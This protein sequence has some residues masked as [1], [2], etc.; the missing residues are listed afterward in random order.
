MTAVRYPNL[1]ALCNLLVPGAGLLIADAMVTGVVVGLIFVVSANIALWG[2]LLIPDELAPWLTGLSIGV[3]GG[4]YV[5]AQLRLAQTVRDRQRRS[6]VARRREILHEVKTLLQREEYRAAEAALAPLTDLAE[7]DLLVAYRFAQAQL[8]AENMGEARRA[9]ERVR[10]L[11]EDRLYHAQ[12]ATAERR[13]EQLGGGA[14]ER[15]S[16]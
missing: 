6:E 9:W 15:D 14:S 8:G 3:A 1:A 5:G 4:T 13:L 11:D 2:T 7:T 10:R 16:I 12:I